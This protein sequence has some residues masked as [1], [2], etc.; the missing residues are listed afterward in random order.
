MLPS[1]ILNDPKLEATE[2]KDEILH[3]RYFK[4]EKIQ[5]KD[6]P[7][8]STTKLPNIDFGNAKNYNYLKLE[9]I[10]LILFG[11]MFIACDCLGLYA[12]WYL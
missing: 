9:V 10:T 6:Q 8:C 12:F 11:T 5:N 4:A 7:T 3:S 1:V 2:T